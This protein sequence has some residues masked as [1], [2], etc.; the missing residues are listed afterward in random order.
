M[1]SEERLA[2]E[3]PPF[4]DLAGDASVSFEFFPPKTE[5]MEEQLWDA[6]TQLAPL[7]PNFVSVTYG[8][9][10]TTRDQTVTTV[11][12]IHTTT[13]LRAAA[14]LTCVASTR[15]EVDHLLDTY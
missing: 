15:H 7:A 12:R 1:T 2:H 10:G 11:L 4:A 3:A 5:K 13:Q 8:A 9:G 6:I 14:H